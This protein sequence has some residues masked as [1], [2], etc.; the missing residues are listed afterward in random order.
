MNKAPNFRTIKKI[1][2]IIVGKGSNTKD[3]LA[4]TLQNTIIETVTKIHLFF[5]FFAN[6]ITP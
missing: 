6:E 4:T 2:Q 5:V 1:V 3:Y